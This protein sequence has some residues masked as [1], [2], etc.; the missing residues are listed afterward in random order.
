MAEEVAY[1]IRNRDRLISTSQS[2][3]TY[4]HLS[5]WV[6]SV[7]SFVLC[8]FRTSEFR[9][10]C[11]HKFRDVFLCTSPFA[12]SLGICVMIL[13]LYLLAF[14][15]SGFARPNRFRLL[16]APYSQKLLQRS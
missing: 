12:R 9:A 5:P 4:F 14:S 16:L 11:R 6:V 7:M 3:L 2:F 10:C 8:F 15:T 13:T 1:Y